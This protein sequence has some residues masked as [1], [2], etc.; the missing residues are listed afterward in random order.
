MKDVGKNKR[1]EGKSG[2][3]Y[4]IKKIS[5]KKGNQTSI[6]SYVKKKKQDRLN[7]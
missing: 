1:M 7:K 5:G 4:Q 3:H 2:L 6:I